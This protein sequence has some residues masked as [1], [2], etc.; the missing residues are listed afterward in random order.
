MSRKEVEISDAK[1]GNRYEI[2]DDKCQRSGCK[3]VIRDILEEEQ[4]TREKEWTAG[5][6]YRQDCQRANEY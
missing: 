1:T 3:G 4:L 2:T 6:D 5:S